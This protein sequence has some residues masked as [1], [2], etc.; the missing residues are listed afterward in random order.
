[1]EPT[2]R[3]SEAG[4]V[5]IPG[6]KVPDLSEPRFHVGAGRSVPG[7][8]PGN[9]SAAWCWGSGHGTPAP[10][11]IAVC[12]GDRL[13]WPVRLQNGNETYYEVV[14]TIKEKVLEVPCRAHS[15]HSGDTRD[16]IINS[17]VNVSFCFLEAGGGE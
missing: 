2:Q 3:A 5:G 16:W 14:V 6:T 12:T 1:M 9:G 15:E 11:L 4:R 7:A 17:I 13:S 10:A 8:C